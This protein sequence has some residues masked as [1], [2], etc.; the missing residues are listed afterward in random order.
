VSSN[1]LIIDSL[2]VHRAGRQVLHGVSLTLNRGEI[3]GLLGANG[4]GKSTLVMTIAGALPATGGHVRLAA[5]G[6]LG[7]AP[8]A[9]RRHGVSVVAEGHR[10]LGALSVLDNLRAAGSNLTLAEL[11]HEID[12]VMAL[13][14]ELRERQKVV[15]HNLSGGQKQMVAIA[16]ALI[17]RP[18]FLLVDE[19]SFGLAPAI[20]LRLG[21]T[22]RQIAARGVG[23]LL[24]EQF[25][26]LALALSTR[27]H[28]MERGKLVFSGTP[29]QLHQRP[30]ILHSAYLAGEPTVLNEKQE[31]LVE[32]EESRHAG[33]HG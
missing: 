23:I 17:G 8:D 10:I 5:T 12:R 18:D 22:L 16:Q 6:L 31:S 2:I 9:V 32:G 4:A 20:V 29:E 19:L 15:A 13:F 1:S 24:I 33:T 30:E 26:T 28:V 11:R 3:A 27:V 7:V 25:T 14:P 21:D